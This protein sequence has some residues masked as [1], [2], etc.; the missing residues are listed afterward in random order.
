MSGKR[1]QMGYPRG[2]RAV[3]RW[4]ATDGADMSRISF[5][6]SP[7]QLLVSGEDLPDDVRLNTQLAMNSRRWIVGV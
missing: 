1:T 7:T 3:L 4:R 2:D 5:P 6:L